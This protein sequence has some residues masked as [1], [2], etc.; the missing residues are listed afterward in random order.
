MGNEF[1][2]KDIFIDFDAITVSDSRGEVYLTKKEYDVL[3]MLINNVGK[4][5][6]REV[7]MDDIWG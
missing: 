6:T 1:E 4:V 2:Y 7:L 5:V 3:I